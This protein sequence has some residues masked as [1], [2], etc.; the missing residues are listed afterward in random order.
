M[1]FEG[2]R[3]SGIISY[4]GRVHDVISYAII[5]RKDAGR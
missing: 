2:I 1:K 5:I 3:R 4:G